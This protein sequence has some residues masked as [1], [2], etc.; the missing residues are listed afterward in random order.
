MAARNSLP[1]VEPWNNFQPEYTH[2]V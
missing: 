2:S 1:L